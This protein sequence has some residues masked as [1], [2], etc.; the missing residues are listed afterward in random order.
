MIDEEHLKELLKV[1]DGH[2]FR[3]EGQELE[4]K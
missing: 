4:F 3:R 2:L 1:K